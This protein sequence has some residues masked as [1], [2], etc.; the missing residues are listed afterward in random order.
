MQLIALCKGLISSPLIQARSKPSQRP[1]QNLL[2]A[3]LTANRKK[4]LMMT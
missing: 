4:S 2:S 3:L 1:K